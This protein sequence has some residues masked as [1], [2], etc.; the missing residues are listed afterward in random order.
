MLIYKVVKMPM[1][2]DDLDKYENYNEL[3]MKI[4]KFLEEHRGTAYTCDEIYEHLY[5]KATPY[6]WEDVVL[7]LPFCW[8]LGNMAMEGKIKSRYAGGKVYYY[9]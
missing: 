1:K 5:K 8:I 9:I 3:E 4:A 7:F 2:V 6:G